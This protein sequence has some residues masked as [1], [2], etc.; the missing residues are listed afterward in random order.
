MGGEPFAKLLLLCLGL[1]F[2]GFHPELLPPGTAGSSGAPAAVAL[3]G[4]RVRVER[5]DGS[6][7]GE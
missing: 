6:G 1:G 2:N 7:R 5:R 4:E 3:T